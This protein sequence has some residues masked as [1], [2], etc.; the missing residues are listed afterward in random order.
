MRALC[1]SA[2]PRSKQDEIHETFCKRAV[3]AMEAT[4]LDVVVK[5]YREWKASQPPSAYELYLQRKREIEAEQ[6]AAGAKT[7]S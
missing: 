7:I 6:G 2:N 1:T 5:E 3:N 4:D